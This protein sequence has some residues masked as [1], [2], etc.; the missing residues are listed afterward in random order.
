MTLGRT[1][2]VDR[3]VR[4]FWDR[5]AEHVPPEWMPLQEPG[6]KFSVEEYGCGHYGCV[7]P[8]NDPN[9]VFK[10][11]SD[12]TE[13]QFV[14]MALTL[15]DTEGIVEYYKI[16]ALADA[17]HRGRQLFVL[18]RQAAKDIG[19]LYDATYLSGRNAEKY[20]Y[21]A[22]DIRNLREGTKHL[23][24]F[25]NW[26][27]E[28]RDKINKTLKRAG[29]ERREET[30]AA[31]WREYEKASY[32]A[33]PRHYRGLPRIGV[34]LTKCWGLAQLIGSTATVY[35]VGLALERYID[36]GILLAD[37]HLNNIGRDKENNL[38]ITDPGHAVV[39]HPRWTHIP[40]VPVI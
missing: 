33:D 9:V 19:L 21:D 39:F 23:Q 12:V 28:A 30:L 6:R 14:A 17:T 25:L 27:G 34:A 36:K 3:N 13:A 8:T 37:V 1:P 35:P 29:P 15:S 10:L 20:G 11:T 24:L 31:I 5:I 38:L 4:S 7:T 18:W 2:W 16:F 26:A 32:D 22:Y 40:E